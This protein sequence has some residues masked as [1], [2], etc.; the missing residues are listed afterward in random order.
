MTEIVQIG[1]RYIMGT[2][3][4]QG[5]PIC[6]A[7]KNNIKNSAKTTDLITIRMNNSAR[8]ILPLFYV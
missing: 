8:L 7:V 3:L 5:S 6:E 2:G 1:E 4:A